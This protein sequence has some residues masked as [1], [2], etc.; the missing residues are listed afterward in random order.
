MKK[1]SKC[2]ILLS[3][4][5]MLGISS[6]TLLQAGDFENNFRKEVSVFLDS[7]QADQ[8]KTCLLPLDHKN[9]WHMQ[10]TGGERPGIQINK[11]NKKQQGYMEKSLR[12]VLSDHGWEMANKVAAQDGKQGLGKYYLTCFGDPR[13]GENFAF[14]I[15]EHHLTIVHLEVA[16]GETSEFG[17]ILLGANPPNLWKVDEMAIM[18]AWKAIKHDK[19][20]ITEKAG[21]ASKPMPKNEG[22]LFSE[23]NEGAQKSIKA[24]W[25][26]RISI[27]QPA[28]QTRIN[29]LHKARGGWGK[30]R[31]AF[32][33]EAA[34]KR[35]SE[36]GRWD[37]KCGLPGMVWDYESSR[38]H[39]HTS[40]WVK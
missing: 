8:Q 20:L 9:R 21:I 33:K 25:I 15:A 31:V 39:I 35:C 38:G 29:K 7:L 3:I 17:P 2:S 14:R 27:F 11:L 40:L 12:L 16:K 10:Y 4:V 34:E 19:I 30:S 1:R 36:G 5:M 32:Y 26:Q 28:I 23:L 24:A 6:V 18:N 22:V 37:F 13:K